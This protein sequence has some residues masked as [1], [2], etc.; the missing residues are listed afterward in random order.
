MPNRDRSLQKYRDGYA[1][2]FFN[3]ASAPTAD[4]RG[5]E[6]RIRAIHFRLQCVGK[7]AL[8]P[9]ETV[10]DAGCGTGLSFPALEDGVGSGGCIVGIDQSSEQLVQARALATH[11]GWRNIALLS[12]PVEDAQI[13]V[14]ADAALFFLTHDIMRTPRAVQNVVSSLRDGGRIVVV[15]R[16]WAPWWRLLTNW[17][18]WQGTRRFVTTFEGFRKPWSHLEE[19]VSSLEVELMFQPGPT[20]RKIGTHVVVARK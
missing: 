8:K 7:L 13:P 10:I 4:P 20:G 19:L 15:G 5:Q 11:N 1:R 3:R 12:S 14:T 9:G 18:T 6:L 16:K 17:R 2:T